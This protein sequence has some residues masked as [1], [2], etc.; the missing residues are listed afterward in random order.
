MIQAL[1]ILIVFFAVTSLSNAQILRGRITTRSG[2]AVPYSTV[3]VQELKQG[4]TSNTK[5]DY[6]IRLP[7]GKYTIFY[8][9]SSISQWLTSR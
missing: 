7:A 2:D 9:F 1:R 8:H 3:Y 6:E 5:G 4:T